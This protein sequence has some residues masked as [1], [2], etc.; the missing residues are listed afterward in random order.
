MPADLNLG[1]IVAVD[2]ETLG[3]NPQR[4]RLCLVQLSA[5]DGVCH[6]VQFEAGAYAAPNLKRMLADP[7]TLGFPFRTLRYGDVQALAGGSDYGTICIAP[8][9]PPSWFA[10]IR[11]S[12][13]SKIW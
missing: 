4:D 9:S 8:R 2:S 1:P 12:T 5:G 6:A 3:L 11:T 10:P 13:A 7:K